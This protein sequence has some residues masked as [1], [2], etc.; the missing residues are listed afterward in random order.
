MLWWHQSA[1]Q[2]LFWGHYFC[3]RM[4]SHLLRKISH[5]TCM[6][7]YIYHRYFKHFQAY[8]IT[9]S[10]IVFSALSEIVFWWTHFPLDCDSWC[11]SQNPFSRG[12][13]R[14]WELSGENKTNM[15]CTDSK[16]VK[17]GVKGQREWAMPTKK[18]PFSSVRPRCIVVRVVVWRSPASPGV[19]TEHLHT[20]NWTGNRS[21]SLWF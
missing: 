6:C 11:F 17:T 13:E 20:N 15:N 14:S 16:V 2:F 3:W 1:S 12:L 8:F 10:V 21:F 18:K 9:A 5:M 4:N 19:N 7:L